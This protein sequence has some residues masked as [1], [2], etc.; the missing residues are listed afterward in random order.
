MALF[1]RAYQ[2]QSNVSLKNYCHLGLLLLSGNKM[3]KN[4]NFQWSTVIIGLSKR[5]YNSN[6]HVK[7]QNET[8]HTGFSWPLSNLKQVCCMKFSP[9]FIIVLNMMS[10]CN[11]ILEIKWD[12]SNLT[13]AGS[14]SVSFLRFVPSGEGLLFGKL[15][16]CNYIITVL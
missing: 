5:L 2:H 14:P 10:R 9:A 13:M 8:L 6:F 16:A 3:S 4:C 11:V 7:Y 1:V 15:V 12:F